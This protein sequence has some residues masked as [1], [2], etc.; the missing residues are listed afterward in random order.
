MWEGLDVFDDLNW[1]IN[2]I[3]REAETRTYVAIDFPRSHSTIGQVVEHYIN[4]DRITVKTFIDFC[5]LN[6]ISNTG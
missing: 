1:D 3:E 4:L 5:R 2:W 6:K